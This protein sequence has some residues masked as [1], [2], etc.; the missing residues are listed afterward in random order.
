[1]GISKNKLEKT[2]FGTKHGR[3]PYLVQFLRTDMLHIF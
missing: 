1:V 2:I 3:L